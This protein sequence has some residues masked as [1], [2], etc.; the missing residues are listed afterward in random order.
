MRVLVT[1]GH[2]RSTLAI[3]R[4]LG[5]RGVSVLVGEAAGSSLASSSRYCGGHVTYPSPCERPQDFYVFLI[6]FLRKNKIDIL[7]PITD[8]TTHI[9]TAHKDEI[10]MYTGLVVP[11]A[12]SFEFV[13][14]KW[15]LLQ[16]AQ[17]LSIPVPQTHFI[18]G[19]ETV[20]EILGLLQYPVVVKPSHSWILAEG[21]WKPTRVHY[22]R[23]ED[24]L[25]RLYEE[26]AYLRYPSLIQ[27]QI[28]G[29]G[30]GVFVLFDRGR[31]VTFFGHRRLRE[32]PPS[33]GISVLRESIL[34]DPLLKDYGMRLLQP[35]NWHGVAMTEYKVDT[36]RGT[37][38]LMEVN[39]RFW[40][41]LQLAVDAGVDFPFLLCQVASGNGIQIPQGYRIGVKTR[42]FVGD[43]I[44]MLYRVLGKEQDLHL[45]P[46]FPSRGQTLLS[47]LKFYERGLHYEDLL[48]ADLNP[49]LFEVLAHLRNI[50]KRR[51]V[52][53]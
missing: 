27:E 9:V 7:I 24:A 8:V 3:T 22:V 44:H 15:R 4:S 41:S 20:R 5:R 45:P 36:R 11:D 49:L 19:P 14:D 10:Q 46:G 2:Q 17:E 1:D 21:G 12:K 13:T 39:G 26:I 31:P 6:N 23:S 40:G 25:L 33:G 34:V 30:L 43:F 37:P 53:A 51:R 48:P 18:R 32:L 16:R 50:L 38:F 35:L 42:W 47:F 28:I 29:P 52:D